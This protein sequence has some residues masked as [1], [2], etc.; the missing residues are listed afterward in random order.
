MIFFTIKALQEFFSQIFHFHPPPQRSNG[1]PLVRRNDP[2]RLELNS[3][4]IKAFQTCLSKTFGAV[5]FS[6]F[7]IYWLSKLYKTATHLL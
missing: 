5:T 6:F 1:P 7:I 2:G 4:P 3:D